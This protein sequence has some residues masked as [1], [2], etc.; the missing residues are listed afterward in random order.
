[1]IDAAING[2]WEADDA[3]YYADCENV[4]HSMLEVFRRSVPE[5]AGR[6]VTR[7]IAAPEP[8][9]AMQFGKLLHACVLEPDRYFNRERCRKFDR[10]TKEGKREGERWDAF[11]AANPTAI[12][13]TDEEESILSA[14]RESIMAHPHARLAIE[15]DGTVETPIRWV[16]AATGQNCKAKPDKILS[17]GLIFDLKSAV[18][19]SPEGFGKAC[20][21]FGYARQAAY[22]LD[23]AYAAVEAD[24]PFLF[25][26][27]SKTEPYEV[28]CYTL[29]AAAL[30]LGREQNKADLEALKLCRIAN[31]W[32]SRWAGVQ[33]VGLP[34][35]AYYQN[36]VQNG[37]R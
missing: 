13:V 8:T 10:R 3:T 27:V 15:A 16:D 26:A 34:N 23:G 22:Y 2:H 11:L 14:M 32:E 25:I 6:F 5:Y 21:N 37:S 36:G 9:P 19:V 29:D 12:V 30:E 24:G 20:A 17:G 35:W 1:M 7:T 28:V 18:D 4:S 33:T 31:D